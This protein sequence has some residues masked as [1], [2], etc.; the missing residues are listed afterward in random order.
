MSHLADNRPQPF[1]P[2]QV[3][4]E[5]VAEAERTGKRL[6]Q[7]TGIT[8]PKGFYTDHR[9][10]VPGIGDA[11]RINLDMSRDGTVKQTVSN[12]I[13]IV[14]NDPVFR[15]LTRY[16]KATGKMCHSDHYLNL[17][18][19]R[20][21]ITA[22]LAEV[23]WYEASAAK[24]D[25]IVNRGYDVSFHSLM[26]IFSSL[27]APA[28]NP[29]DEILGHFRL[30]NP[31]DLPH[32]RETFDLFL[33]KR[34]LQTAVP[35]ATGGKVTF[36]ND[37]APTL[38]GGQG[39]GKTLFSK[40]LAVDDDRYLDLGA[41]RLDDFGSRDQAMKRAGLD[42]VEAG[43]YR[44]PKE[45][46][47]LKAGLS[48]TKE[49]YR[50]P[51]ARDNVTVPR[52][53]SMLL[54]TN[55][56]HFLSDGTGNR[57]FY[58]IELEDIDKALFEKRRLFRELS[59]FYWQWAA[60]FIEEHEDD[61][62]AALFTIRDS[63][64]LT[65]YLN[66]TREGARHVDSVEETIERYFDMVREAVASG[67]Y[68]RLSETRPT[69]AHHREYYSALEA[70]T[71]IYPHGRHPKSFYRVFAEVAEREGLTYKVGSIGG[72]RLR[73]W[74]PID[75]DKCN[76]LNSDE[77]CSGSKIVPAKMDGTTQVFEF[78][79]IK[80]YQ[81]SVS[82]TSTVTRN[83]HTPSREN[84][85]GVKPVHGGEVGIVRQGKHTPLEGSEQGVCVLH[86]DDLDDDE[87]GTWL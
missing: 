82:S 28:D 74:V 61:L 32:V 12:L 87:E 29:L 6:P 10:H 80:E 79:S 67:D 31:A 46:G 35:E 8:E 57:R 14:E 66:R 26:E 43:E 47:V 2:A 44:S 22:Y 51:Y 37:V 7:V 64:A 15:R 24:L 86:R 71:L 76:T 4:P 20:N 38:Q 23:H 70:V 34:A 81:E 1:D 41:E 54:T 63:E 52:T 65:E 3:S 69:Q 84:P 13:L 56:K 40:A 58:P 45:I 68:S 59:G 33:K 78:S 11:L 55:T 16:D 30:K 21:K 73:H 60:S 48:S 9:D 75:N 19:L 62:E 72:K 27:P 5:A 50:V 18:D 42:I 25:W 49:V 39:I 77:P 53:F 85:K 36:P 83:I 17:D